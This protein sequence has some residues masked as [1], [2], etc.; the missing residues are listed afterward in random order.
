MKRLALLLCLCL[1]LLY[2]A[3]AESAQAP[4]A[5]VEDEPRATIYVIG[6]GWHAGLAIRRA[7]IP[8]GLIPESAD[9]PAADYLEL[10]WGDREYYQA[11]NP[12]LWLTLKAGLWPSA[13]VLHVVGIHGAVADRFG[14]FEILR[15]D[16]AR[17]GVVKLA[18]FIHSSF[19]RDGAAKATPIGLGRGRDSLFYPANGTFHVF[20]TCNTW[21]A[22][23]LEAVGYPI[24][25]P[26]TA[27][28]LMAQA[29]PFAVPVDSDTAIPQ[30]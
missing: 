17:S 20:N 15:F 12:G 10:G 11:D 23:A 2:P 29:R 14:G 13:G 21:T 30:E 5:P 1:S 25:R 6:Q 28:Q 18:D 26:F 7:D 19:A 9:F 3:R 16:V 4:P 24:G 8:P 27:D 22:R